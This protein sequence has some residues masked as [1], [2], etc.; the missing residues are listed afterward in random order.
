M[1][2]NSIRK[3]GGFTIAEIMI[4]LVL[5][6][7]VLAWAGSKGTDAWHNYK[8]GRMVD[9]T[10]IISGAVNELY[11]MTQNYAGLTEANADLVAIVPD[12]LKQGG[13]LT[14]PWNKAYKLV[15]ADNTFTIESEFPN[16]KLAIRAEQRFTNAVRAGSKVTVTMGSEPANPAS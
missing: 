7:I 15:G 3:Q 1:R 8:I 6:G 10:N 14:N 13:K 5:G 16:D 11:G 4:V 9:D 2:R 12:N